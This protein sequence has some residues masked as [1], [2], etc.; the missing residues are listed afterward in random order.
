[1]YQ[2]MIDLHLHLD[3][4][5]SIPF[6]QTYLKRCGQSIPADLHTALSVSPS[7]KSL[8]D[9]LERFSLPKRILQ[10]ADALELSAYDLVKRLALEGLIY[11]EIR[12]AP[13]F[14]C[15][16]GLT[17]SNVVESVIRGVHHAMKEF[18]SIKI[19]LLLCMIVGDEH[20]Q[21]TLQTALHYHG[22][23]VAGLDLA[24]PEGAVPLEAYKALFGKAKEAGLPFTIHAGECGS[25]DN[26]LK[27]VEFGAQRIGHGVAAVQD[28]ACMELLAE[29]GTILECCFTSNL[30]TRAV[31]MPAAHPIL[32]FYRHGLAVTVNTDNLTVS[33]TSLAKEHQALMRF[34]PLTDEDFLQMDY[35]AIRGAF[36]S[37]ADK[38]QLVKRL[39]EHRAI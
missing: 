7:C 39:K 9:Y 36:L 20:N 11:A 1:M 30:Q 35:N 12:F 10:Y 14:H 37:N 5:L 26:I 31:S 32:S 17:Q 22:N 3:G 38:A 19:G 34:F 23:G 27:A 29:R 16:L 6:V 33:S 2:G 25:V 15:E 24:G 21:E 18:P 28:P 13:A 8:T 4:S